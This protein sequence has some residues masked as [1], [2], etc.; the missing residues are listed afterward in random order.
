MSIDREDEK[1]EEDEEYGAK[2]LHV[3]GAACV[4]FQQSS[5]DCLCARES[6]I[7]VSRYVWMMTK[8]EG[9]G[10]GGKGS[11]RGSSGAGAL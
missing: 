6:V 9:G 7:S 11:E 5:A 10:S 1:G 2:V 4:C 3:E 8:V